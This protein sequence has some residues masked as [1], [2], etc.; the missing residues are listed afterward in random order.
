MSYE[1][2]SIPNES[3]SCA[4]SDYEIK[5]EI[6]LRIKSNIQ[7]VMSAIYEK[8]KNMVRGEKMAYFKTIT[9]EE[10]K[11]YDNYMDYQRVLKGK[12]KDRAK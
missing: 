8:V 10:K 9:A 4:L 7:V 5:N 11:A 12:N 3:Y 6:Y 2:S 1:V